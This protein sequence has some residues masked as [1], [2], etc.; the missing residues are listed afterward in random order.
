[1]KK[2]LLTMLLP[3][4]ALSTSWGQSPTTG[5]AAFDAELERLL[6]ESVPFISVDE[7][8]KNQEEVTILDAREKS[9]FAVSHLPGAQH[10]GYDNFDPASVENLPKNGPIV[11]YCSVGYR[12]EKIGEKL[13]QLGFTNVKNLYGSIFAWANKGYP[14]ENTEGKTKQ[15]HTY[16]EEWSQWVKN[17]EVEKIW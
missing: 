3:I 5:N 7:L 12:S 4:F 8:R 13:Q 2:F 1:M 10:I 9:E 17:P 6:S 15:V 14:L 11:L 16:N